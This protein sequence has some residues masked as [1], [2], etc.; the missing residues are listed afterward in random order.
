[1]LNQLTERTNKFSQRVSIEREV[2]SIINGRYGHIYPLAGLSKKAYERW[3]M[4]ALIKA[5]DIL[6]YDTLITEIIN[7]IQ[8]D[9]D[10][11]KDVFEEPPLVLMDRPT[12]ILLKKLKNEVAK[13]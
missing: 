8:I 7:R 4:N 13:K 5:E 1:M 12:D 2:L 6:I 10:A 9:C 3:K 11:S